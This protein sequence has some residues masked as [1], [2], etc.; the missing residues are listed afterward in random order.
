MRKLNVFDQVS[1]DGF[2]VDADGDMMWA[3]KDDAEWN[4]FV[5]E[6]ASGGGALLFGRITYE[7][8]ASFWPTAAGKAV[9]PVVSEAMTK[10]PK[11]VC[12]RTLK[13]PSWANATVLSENLE[14]D[15]R[16]LKKSEGPDVTI[17]GSGSIVSAL[18]KARLID[19]YQIAINPIVLGRG[20]TLFE[21]LTERYALKLVRS[22]AFGNGNVVTWY[23]P[24]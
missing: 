14:R 11:Y 1:L 6:N 4:A 19:G 10:A 16:A 12:S 13:K 7:M 15:V 9:N 8:M 24:T 21:G 3:K 17:L 5:S 22:R 2:F 20:R 23:E 18:T